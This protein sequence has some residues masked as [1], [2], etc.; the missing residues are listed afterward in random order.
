M[1]LTSKLRLRKDN[2]Q[3]SVDNGS[4]SADDVDEMDNENQSIL[5]SIIAQLRPG[6]DLTRI[7]LP[8][9]VLEKKSMLERIGNAFFTPQLLLEANGTDD[10]LR[11]FMLIVI[12]Y[13]SGWHI[14]PKAV[15]KPLNPVL[16]EIFSCYWDDLPENKKAFYIAE[17]TSHHPPKSSYFYLLPESKIKVDGVVVPRSKF[18]G[19]SSAAM[20][21]G[22]ARLTL[23]EHDEEYTMTQPNIY[24]RGIL[25]GKLKYELGDQMTIKCEKLGFEA[26]I[27]FKTKGFISGDYDVIEG[28]I[29]DSSSQKILASVSGKWNEVMTISPTDVK[30]EPIVLDTRKA[31]VNTPS[32]KPLEHQADNESRKLWKKTIDALHKRDHTVATEEKFKV[33][34]AQRIRAK[35]RVA[36]G[37]DF[38]PAIFKPVQDDVPFVLRKEMNVKDEDPQYLIHELLDLHPIT[39]FNE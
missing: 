15:K 25:F 32:V 39:G 24:C 23:G 11:R 28:V 20:M 29:K 6:S 21:E 35:E 10:P 3:D 33:E 16:G 17:Q 30:L 7:T 26:S 12:W 9:F 5:L 34:E 22:L 19:N 27:E 2:S 8:T 4:Q 38:V 37:E 31:S 36:N 1:G 18:L 13:L 14:A